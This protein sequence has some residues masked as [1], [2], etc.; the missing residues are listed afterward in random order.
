MTTDT[1]DQITLPTAERIRHVIAIAFG[2]L[3]HVEKVKKFQEGR[4]DEYWSCLTYGDMATYDSNAL[5]LLV[6]GA[7]R[8]GCRVGINAAG[9]RR[10]K[11]TVWARPKRTGE[12]WERHPTMERAVELYDQPRPEMMHQ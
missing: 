7:H 1:I 12:F 4:P 8:Y 9:P 10:L 2:G 11:I 3:H 6:I 5:T